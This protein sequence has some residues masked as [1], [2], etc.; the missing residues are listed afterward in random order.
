MSRVNGKI[1]FLG[2]GGSMGVPVVACSCSVCTSSDVKNKRL[3]VSALIQVED[4]IF[5][6]D[7]GPDFRTQALTNNIMRLD[8]LLITHPHFDHVAGIDDLRV[9]HFFHKKTVPCLLSQESLKAIEK[10]HAYL[11][12]SNEKARFDF[13]VLKDS[14]GEVMFQG[15]KWH[16]TSF[17]QKNDKVTGFR[18]GNMAYILDI[19]SF[20]E[21]IFEMLEGV[22]ILIL[23]ALKYH[24]SPSHFSIEEAVS[25]SQKVGA[26][27][28]YLSHLAHEVDYEEG[29]RILPSHV[30]LAYDGLEVGFCAIP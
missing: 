28:T 9:F 29:S 1:K 14:Q 19:R 16:Y 12:E 25:F 5:L 2:T 21:D 17:L 13:H 30:K 24:P 20:S 7:A 22:E 10:S 26:K 23:S 6:I 11:F 4:K 8:G 27:K 18:L 15:L 3:R